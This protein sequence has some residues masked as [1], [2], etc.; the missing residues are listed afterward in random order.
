MMRLSREALRGVVPERT[1]GRL[2]QETVGKDPW[3]VAIASML[4][5]RT[6]RQQAEP[7]L[8]ELLNRWPDAAALSRAD[9]AEVEEVVRPCGLHRNRARQLVRFS[10]RYMGDGWD[11][12]RELPG[13]GLY[14]ADAVGLVCFGCTDLESSDKVLAQCANDYRTGVRT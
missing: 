1:T 5:N 14:V 4:L 2:L 10:N 11:D 12:L 8:R 9:A 3:K 7:V 13:V 6:R